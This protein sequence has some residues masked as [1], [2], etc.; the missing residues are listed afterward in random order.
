MSYK[1][2]FS[3]EKKKP[4]AGAGGL[5]AQGFS[6][7]VEDPGGAL[8]HQGNPQ[9]RSWFH[10]VLLGLFCVAPASATVGPIK[11]YSILPIDYLAI[12]R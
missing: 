9:F 11:V 3:A 8:R 5:I 10:A 2:K 12:R 7:A 4:R 1:Y 6:E